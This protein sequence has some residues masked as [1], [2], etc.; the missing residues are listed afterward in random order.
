MYVNFIYSSFFWGGGGFPKAFGGISIYTNEMQSYSAL[1]DSSI[2]GTR[3]EGCLSVLE[4]GT[5]Q[6]IIVII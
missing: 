1:S 2:Y 5:E 6:T 4:G 3:G